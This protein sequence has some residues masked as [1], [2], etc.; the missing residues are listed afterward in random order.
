MKLFNS[1]YRNI[2]IPHSFP[3]SIRDLKDLAY[4][5]ANELKLFML[6]TGVPSLY[7][8]LSELHFEH[9]CLYVLYIRLLCDDD[10]EFKREQL[11]EIGFVW[12]EHLQKLYGISEMTFTAHAH[13]HLP[14]QVFRFGPLHKLSCFAF[15]GIIK[16][17]KSVVT[18]PKHI[19]EQV[20]SRVISL[21][22][23]R[24]NADSNFV[25][26]DFSYLTRNLLS[27]PIHAA[28]G[29]VTQLK[30]SFP[31]GFNADEIILLNAM[32]PDDKLSKLQVFGRYNHTNSTFYSFEYEMN[33]RRCSSIVSILS[34]GNLIYGQVL[35][36][37]K[38][39]EGDYFIFKMFT[40]SL[41]TANF[42]NFKSSFS[43]LFVDFKFE[44]YFKVFD[45]S[46]FCLTIES[47]SNIKANCIAVHIDDNYFML[48]ETLGFE[49]D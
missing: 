18:G 45:K 29:F 34:K 28:R 12:H 2:K 48:T 23:A 47:C 25:S 7:L 37:F 41:D 22:N 43:K 14:Q 27:Q 11:E 32:F 46:K 4:W 40:G 42:F 5:K 24:E 30:S 38:L 20:C 33:M 16:H 36:F 13:L 6:Y 3:R 10:A 9:F 19:G 17:L 35:K 8:H 31:T 39:D 26:N 44:K 21:K 49:H 15:E 1:Q